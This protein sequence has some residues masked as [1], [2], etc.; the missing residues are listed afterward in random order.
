MTTCGSLC[1]SGPAKVAATRLLPHPGSSQGALLSW[2]TSEGGREGEWGKS[3]PV[4]RG[5]DYLLPLPKSDTVPLQRGWALS[6]GPLGK[7][8]EQ[9]LGV[10]SAW[11]WTAGWMDG[12]VLQ[13]LQH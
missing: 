10:T 3:D 7:E 12:W 4:A 6:Q 2:E 13:G 11:E 9:P 1:G 8:R 5:L